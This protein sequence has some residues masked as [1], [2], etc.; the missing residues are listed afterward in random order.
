M[1]CRSGAKHDECDEGADVLQGDW[2][3]PLQVARALE[4]LDKLLLGLSDYSAAENELNGKREIRLYA[5]LKRVFSELVGVLN[6]AE[7]DLKYSGLGR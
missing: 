5:W 7:K 6:M 2:T 3:Q 4:A 1:I